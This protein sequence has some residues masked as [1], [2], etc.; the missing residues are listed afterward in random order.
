MKIYRTHKDPITNAYRSEVDHI[1]IACLECRFV[2]SWNTSGPDDILYIAENGN[3]EVRLVELN[4]T[5][6]VIS[7][8][9]GAYVTILPSNVVTYERQDEEESIYIDEDVRAGKGKNKPVA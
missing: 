4:G 9:K 5:R 3:A 2:G 6:K 8:R 7:F 1:Y